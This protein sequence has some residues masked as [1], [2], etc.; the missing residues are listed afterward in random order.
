MLLG[1]YQKSEAN[2]L[3]VTRTPA[4]SPQV[5]FARLEDAAHL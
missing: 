5:F 3:F 4:S 1:R 2:G